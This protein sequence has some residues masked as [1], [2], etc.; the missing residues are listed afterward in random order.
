MYKSGVLTEGY[1]D[2]MLLTIG[3]HKLSHSPRRLVICVSTLGSAVEAI[4]LELVVPMDYRYTPKNGLLVEP[5][6]LT[7]PLV[8]KIVTDNVDIGC[9]KRH[10]VSSL[11]VGGVATD[12][13]DSLKD[14]RPEGASTELIEDN[15]INKD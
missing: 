15:L 14:K 4:L 12:I 6:L 13:T 7:P 2:R 9:K 10:P 3:I 5:G 8:G 11:D 1:K